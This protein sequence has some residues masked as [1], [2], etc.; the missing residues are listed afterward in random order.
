MIVLVVGKGSI[1]KRYTEILQSKKI[2]FFNISTK[3]INRFFKNN[4]SFLDSSCNKIII[5]NK[6][7]DHI[8]TL[9]K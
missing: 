2:V 4:L 9:K 7:Y 5:C 1:S 6:T 3:S 8:K